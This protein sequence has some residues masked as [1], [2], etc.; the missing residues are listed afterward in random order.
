MINHSGSLVPDEALPP[1]EAP[2]L[3]M[4]AGHYRFVQMARYHTHRPQGRPD[5]QLLY[6]AGGTAQFCIDGVWQR[7]NEGGAVLYYPYEEQEYS[8]HLEDNPDIYWVHFT[9]TQAAEMVERF[10]FRRGAVCAAGVDSR[11]PELFEG[12]IREL[13]LKRPLMEELSTILVQELLVRMARCNHESHTDRP[14]SAMIEKA[15]REMERRFAEP[16]TVAALADQFHVE[17]CWFSR[18]FRRQMGTSPQRYLMDIRM[19]KARELLSTTDCTISE[20][21]RLSG[22]DNPLYFSRLFS[23]LYGCPPRDYRRRQ[24]AGVR[25]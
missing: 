5:Y 4:S 7:V 19:T 21:A 15:V 1:Y 22:Y 11:Y 10:G 17:V 18:L 20:A 13:Q 14:R 6:V 2:M 24:Q 25:G 8:Y 23:K 9:G 12:I 3:V 16:L